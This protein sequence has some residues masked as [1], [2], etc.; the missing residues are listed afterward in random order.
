MKKL[1]APFQQLRWKLTLSYTAVTVGALLL[2]EVVLA[3]IALL[4]AVSVL[5]S[6]LLPEILA[7]NLSDVS[8]AQF[9]PY[10]AQDPPDIDGLNNWLRLLAE[11]SDA[12][13]QEASTSGF[14]VNLTRDAETLVVVDENGVL[15][16]IWPPDALGGPALGEPFDSRTLPG[17]A[18]PLSA[19]LAGVTDTTLLTAQQQEEL[20]IAAPVFDESGEHV[21]GAVVLSLVY[22]ASVSAFIGPLASL[23]GASLL[24]FTVMAGVVGTLFGFV[25]ARTLTR[26]LARLTAASDAWSQGDFSTFVDDPSGDE[27][28]QL[29]RRLNRMAEQLQNLMAVREDVAALEER[30]R[31]A[32]DLHDSA[33]QQAFAASAQIGAARALL[34]VDPQAAEKHLAEAEAL[35]DALRRELTSLIHELRPVALGSRGLAAALEAYAGEWARRNEIEV[36]V[37]VVGEPVLRPQVE[38][39]L[40]RIVQEALANVARH[41]GARHA[42]VRLHAD[43]AGVSLTIAD[44]GAG[45]DPATARRGF[46]LRSMSERAAAL[47]G[48]LDVQSGSD[49]TRISVRCPQG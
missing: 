47:G 41:S 30:N 18:E 28:G 2:V 20:I 1:L 45:F 11:A 48:T 34:E 23:I 44:D 36:E 15:V 35:T 5:R 8:A 21:L 49:G 31:I 39:A 24:A 40:F 25:T 9:R 3:G 42:E 32:R 13:L 29:A 43:P 7:S 6:N 12:G 10:L 26:R 22:P 16:A 19:A 17:A 46:G 14:S 33:K 38:E 4:A 27:L 37:R